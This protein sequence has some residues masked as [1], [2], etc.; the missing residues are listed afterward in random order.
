M[1]IVLIGMPGSGKSTVGALLAKLTGHTFIDTDPWIEQRENL[2][3]QTIVDREGV[4]F[5]KYEEARI[6]ELLPTITSPSIIAT[7][8]S[9]VYG[10]RVMSALKSIARI[11][12]I[13]ADEATL[14]S[15]IGNTPR[16]I[17]ADG[18]TF[19][20]LFDERQPLYH[21]WADYV[22]NGTQAPEDVAQSILVLRA[23][24]QRSTTTLHS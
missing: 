14:R 22:V 3:L 19:S 4:G 1:H 12:F 5:R 10:T 8:G 17:S 18:A 2:P 6:I 15:R 23:I 21:T 13:F 7:G 9:V 16:G 24:T 20:E 11:A